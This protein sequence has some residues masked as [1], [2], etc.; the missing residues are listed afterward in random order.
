MYIA[1]KLRQ[2]NSKFQNFEKSAKVHGGSYERELMGKSVV[3]ARMHVDLAKSFDDLGDGYLEI[4]TE[5]SKNSKVAIDIGAGTGWL[6]TYLGKF[7]DTVISVEPTREGIVLGKK[8]LLQESSYSKV[9]YINQK[10]EDFLAA[11]Y[12]VSPVMV[13]FQTVLSHL[14]DKQVEN[15][16]SQFDH[17]LPIGSKVIFSEVYGH[18]QAEMMWFVRE[19]IWWEMNLP[20]W[21]IDFFSMKLVDRQESKGFVATRVK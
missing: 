17:A 15:I 13:F 2:L 20:N 7:F 9:S 21:E 18:P 5:F 6:S 19:S 14:P 8:L 12:F 10:A 11:A 1:S 16:L 3:E 4:I